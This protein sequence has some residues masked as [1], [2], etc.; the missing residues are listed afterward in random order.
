[1]GPLGNW[2]MM[3]TGVL[4]VVGDVTLLTLAVLAF[5]K[6][7][8]VPALAGSV[9]ALVATSLGG[10]SVFLLPLLQLTDWGMPT[11]MAIYGG[12][13]AVAMVARLGVLGVLGWVL[14]HHVPWAGAPDG[15][16]APGSDTSPG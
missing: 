8:T 3:I 9:A 7:R 12:V 4:G 1:M 10:A 15:A 11:T 6:V 2:A 14:W 16:G 13:L 5:F